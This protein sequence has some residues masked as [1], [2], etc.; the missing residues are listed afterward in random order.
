MR[1][2]LILVAVAATFL[3][4]GWLAGSG[5]TVEAQAP[6]RWNCHWELSTPTVVA[7]PEGEL[8]RSG[9]NFLVDQCTGA[10]WRYSNVDGEA[11]WV[12]VPFHQ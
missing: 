9:P 11:G 7:G 3:V 6:R 2:Q 8:I 5:G 1:D 4:A 10:T 12:E